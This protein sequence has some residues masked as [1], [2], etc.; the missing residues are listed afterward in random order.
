MSLSSIETVTLCKEKKQNETEPEIYVKNNR[1][2]P[3]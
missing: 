3:A 2:M 1:K